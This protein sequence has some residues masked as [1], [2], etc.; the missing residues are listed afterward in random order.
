MVEELRNKLNSLVNL[1]GFN[2]LEVIECSQKLDQIIIKIQKK[3]D[4][5]DI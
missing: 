1:Y 3:K 2:H 4:H 5:Q